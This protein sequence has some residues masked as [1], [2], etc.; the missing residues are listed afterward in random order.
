MKYRVAILFKNENET[1]RS[2]LTEDFV[3]AWKFITGKILGKVESAW[4]EAVR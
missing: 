4:I 3:S 2:D 1:W